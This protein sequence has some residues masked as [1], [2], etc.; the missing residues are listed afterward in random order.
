MNETAKEHEIPSATNILSFEDMIQYLKELEQDELNRS[1]LIAGNWGFNELEREKTLI[2]KKIDARDNEYF[3]ENAPIDL[4][5]RQPDNIPLLVRVIQ[6]KDT[7]FITYITKT[8]IQPLDKIHPMVGFE[9]P[10]MRFVSSIS[11]HE[12]L[13]SS[14]IPCEGIYSVLLEQCKEYLAAQYDNLT[15]NLLD[16]LKSVELAVLSLNVYHI[17]EYKRI[18]KGWGIKR[19]SKADYYGKYKTILERVTPEWKIMLLLQEVLAMRDFSLPRIKRRHSDIMNLKK[20][21]EEA[22]N[23]IIDIFQKVKDKPSSAILGSAILIT[24]PSKE[25]LRSLEGIFKQALNIA[26]KQ[27]LHGWIVKVCLQWAEKLKQRMLYDKTGYDILLMSEEQATKQGILLNWQ[28]LDTAAA[29]I[30]IKYGDGSIRLLGL[31]EN[32]QW[33]LNVECSWLDLPSSIRK[34]W[35]TGKYFVSPNTVVTKFITSKGGHTYRASKKKALEILEEIA[36]PAADKVEDPY[37]QT[38]VH[39][40]I[41]RLLDKKKLGEE[42]IEKIISLAKKTEHLEAILLIIKT[43]FYSSNAIARYLELFKEQINEPTISRVIEILTYWDYKFLEKSEFLD[44]LNKLHKLI[45]EAI[46]QGK[47]I[48][49]LQ[50][51]EKKL[52]LIALGVAS[53]APEKV[54]NYGEIL[55]P[56][57]NNDKYTYKK[58]EILIKYLKANNELGS[59]EKTIST[60]LCD[61]LGFLKEENSRYEGSRDFIRAIELVIGA[62]EKTERTP[63]NIDYFLEILPELL[64]CLKKTNKKSVPSLFARYIELLSSIVNSQRNTVLENKNLQDKLRHSTSNLKEI[65]VCYLQFKRLIIKPED[66]I[67]NA[68]LL[69]NLAALHKCNL[70]KRPPQKN[71]RTDLN[72]FLQKFILK[73]SSQVRSKAVKKSLESIIKDICEKFI[74]KLIDKCSGEFSK[75]SMEAG[76]VTACFDYILNLLDGCLKKIEGHSSQ[77]SRLHTFSLNIKIH[78]KNIWTTETLTS[79][80]DCIQNIM[81]SLKENIAK[82]ERSLDKRKQDYRQALQAFFLREK[83]GKTSSEDSIE[84]KKKTPTEEY[85]PKIKQLQKQIESEKKLIKTC[86]IILAT[87]WTALCTVKVASDIKLSSGKILITAQKKERVNRVMWAFHPLSEVLASLRNNNE[88]PDD[89]EVNIGKL[90]KE[91]NVQ[92]ALLFAEGYSSSA[93]YICEQIMG[94][95]NKSEIFKESNSIKKLKCQLE[96]FLGAEESTLKKND[97]KKIV[98]QS[99]ELLSPYAQKIFYAYMFFQHNDTLFQTE[100]TDPEEQQ[101]KEKLKK[102]KMIIEDILQQLDSRYHS[103]VKNTF[104]IVAQHLLDI[105]KT[106]EHT[107]ESSQAQDLLKQLS[108][109]PNKAM[110][111]FSN[112][113]KKAMEFCIESTKENS[114]L[115]SIQRLKEV[116]SA[117]DNAPFWLKKYDEIKCLVATL[118][119]DNVDKIIEFFNDSLKWKETKNIKPHQ[120]YQ[121]P[122]CSQVLFNTH[123]KLTKF[124]QKINQPENT[125]STSVTFFS[126][127]SNADNSQKLLKDLK[128][129]CFLIFSEGSLE[130]FKEHHQEQNEM[131]KKYTLALSIITTLKNTRS[132][133]NWWIMPE[134]PKDGEAKMC[135]VMKETF[136]NHD[137]AKRIETL[138][139][140]EGLNVILRGDDRLLVLNIGALLEKCENLISKIKEAAVPGNSERDEDWKRNKFHW[141]FKRDLTSNKLF[142]IMERSFFQKD[143][144]LATS[145]LNNLQTLFQKASIQRKTNNRGEKRFRLRVPVPNLDAPTL[146]QTETTPFPEFNEKAETDACPVSRFAP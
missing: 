8:F 44:L 30:L 119:P 133:K 28:E 84:K 108:A 124:L 67:L 31:G 5:G 87:I 34:T 118:N 109:I 94:K 139:K 43:F 127:A 46:S 19:R 58:I 68:E 120:F 117:P 25:Y 62:Y 38:A 85:A 10:N 11:F 26:E 70:P 32:Q 24:D 90:S 121:L 111:I 73:D 2:V 35:D 40:A 128:V 113:I 122:Y 72:T 142:A 101:I 83:K 6:T 12:L 7:D 146:T 81:A 91:L 97:I 13:Y 21:L 114:D 55:L 66:I 29:P 88:I 60:C 45:K 144:E 53:V 141:V 49:V 18:K 37:L 76:N 52:L 42:E 78:K 16:E 57:L 132:T 9:I 99:S 51:A 47:N 123:A 96:L 41:M 103:S 125:S 39:I 126:A 59:F 23:E 115:S 129:L 112:T 80:Q 61:Y 22:N 131:R 145:Y 69:R 140:E 110:N 48:S 27:G 75:N 64:L 71:K 86:E 77:I 135:A 50:K 106:A 63:E 82:L 65:I 107:E 74:R 137:E 134:Y 92:I 98:D 130:D 105:I 33:K 20:R 138:L 100:E 36:L 116:L 143:E 15:N 1:F 3:S 4:F 136:N 17:E 54:V 56:F 95:I 102:L 14:N 93:V 89:F 79:F 104:N